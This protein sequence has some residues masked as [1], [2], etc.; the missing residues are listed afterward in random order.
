MLFIC[1]PLST[2]LIFLLV[3]VVFCFMPDLSLPPEF[4][5]RPACA[6]DRVM[7]RALLKAFRQEVVP[8]IS[9]AEW[10]L[11][12]LSAG[13]LFLAGGWLTLTIGIQW[14]LRLLVI[15]AIMILFGII[16]T[17]MFTWNEDW[18]NFWVI[19]H[20][21]KLVAC[22]KLRCY[23]RYS[24]LHDL[25]VLP[26]WRNHQLGS[27]LVAQIGKKATKPLYLTCLPSLMQFYMRLGFMPV[28]TKTL[29]P[30]LQYDLGIPGRVDVVP[31]VLK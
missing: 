21:G 8:P 19:E 10:G 15:P 11:R 23:P 28:L 30:L 25:F 12:F 4:T 14:L 16:I 27:C 2:F 6:T 5:L 7:I 1:K 20:N 31:L 17:L 24:L 13:L 26:E 18:V 9:W 29:S 3:I 22:A